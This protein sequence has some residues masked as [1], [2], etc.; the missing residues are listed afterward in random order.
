VKVI[1]FLSKF[2]LESAGVTFKRRGGRES[3]SPPVGGIILAQ[4]VVRTVISETKRI[5]RETS[6]NL[7]IQ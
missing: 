6:K 3:L 4:P 1:V 7:F 5:I 2:L